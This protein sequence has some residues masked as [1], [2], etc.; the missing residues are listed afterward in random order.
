MLTT[1]I[2]TSPGR[3][4]W[5]ARAADSVPGD[6]IVVSCP[7]YEIGKLEWVVE[8]TNL[9]RFLFI[10]DSV[11]VTPG[12]YEVLSKY[13]HSV[14]LLGDPGPFGC[15]LGVYERWA[16]MNT[17]F[18]KITTKAEAVKAELSWTAKYLEVAGDVPVLFPELS[19]ENAGPP[20]SHLNRRNLV[21]SNEYV[22]K[23]KG[24]WRHDQI[25]E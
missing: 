14:A 3:G 16:L 18:P 9:R 1:V 24:T 10:Q 20:V 4:E 7:G 22:T 11:V 25:A 13:K 12:L 2:G 6:C 19:D 8:N 5:A 15:Y 23:Y 17:G 21:L